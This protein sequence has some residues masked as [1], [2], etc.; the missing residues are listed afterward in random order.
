M[1]VS[2]P[3]VRPKRRPSGLRTCRGVYEHDVT[4]AALSR[5]LCP[6]SCRREQFLRHCWWA[7]RR[8]V[9]QRNNGAFL[10]TCFE[11]MEGIGHGDVER[12]I[13]HAELLEL[14][15]DVR[16]KLRHWLEGKDCSVELA[17][18]ER[19]YAALQLQ[20][21][22]RRSH[23]SVRGSAS[24]HHERSCTMTAGRGNSELDAPQRLPLCARPGSLSGSAAALGESC[25]S[26]SCFRSRLHRRRNLRVAGAAAARWPSPGRPVPP[27]S[28]S[29]CRRE[30]RSQ[31]AAAP[32]ASYYTRRTSTLPKPP[33]SPQLRP[34]S[35][36]AARAR[37]A[38]ARRARCRPPP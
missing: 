1:R 36:P 24:T 23:A 3:I 4:F 38:A 15:G 11:P 14:C 35:I 6:R 9:R 29:P 27:H 22:Q 12:V 16:D 13:C 32:S 2:P 25:R 20:T 37:T 30:L 28:P 10:R 31:C 18:T 33:G 8:F 7:I 26:R 17:S 21:Q 5:L 34:R 19:L